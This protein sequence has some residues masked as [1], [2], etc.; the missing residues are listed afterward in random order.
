M[1]RR[2]PR[3]LDALQQHLRDTPLGPGEVHHVQ[4]RHDEHC[5]FWDGHDCDCEPEILSRD[6]R[7]ENDR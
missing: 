5:P 6:P 1:S 2:R 4:V 7:R 3:Y